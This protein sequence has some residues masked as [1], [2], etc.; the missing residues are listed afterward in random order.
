M[1]KQSEDGWSSD[2]INFL[3]GKLKKYFMNIHGI[4]PDTIMPSILSPRDV[5]KCCNLVNDS[6]Y[7]WII[8][9]FWE[10]P[11]K[12]VIDEVELNFLANRIQSR[13]PR[14]KNR[15]AAFS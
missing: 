11:K 8:S 13:N 5:T 12:V 1:L 10:L 7:S 3:K 14:N 6:S 4:E 9:F 15:L 2:Q